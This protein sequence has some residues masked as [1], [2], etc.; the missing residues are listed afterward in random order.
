MKVDP[1][2][3]SVYKVVKPLTIS[4]DS[5]KSTVIRGLSEGRLYVAS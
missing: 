3:S 2:K 1:F 4:K 5:S